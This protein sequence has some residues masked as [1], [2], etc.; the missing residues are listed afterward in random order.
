MNWTIL[1]TEADYNRASER[2][3]EIFHAESGTPEN[4]EMSLLI[5][6]IQD[7]DNRYYSLPEVDVLEVIKAKMKER[8]LKN[9][10]LESVIGSKGYV[11]AILAGKREITLKMAKR[12]KDYFNIPAEMFLQVR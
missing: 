3:M 4:D 5:L 7:Y 12:L 6:L 1:K 11:S 8:G 10:D 2:M 9:K